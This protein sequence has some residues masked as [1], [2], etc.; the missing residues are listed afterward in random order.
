MGPKQADIL[1]QLRDF[2]ATIMKRLD[3]IDANFEKLHESIQLTKEIA[4]EAANTAD[5]ALEATKTNEKNNDM[6][7]KKIGELEERLEDQVNRSMRK[8][9]VFKGI[10]GDEKNWD[11]TA[12]KLSSII[13]QMDKTLTKDEINGWIERSHRISPVADRNRNTTNERQ[14]KT[15]NIVAQFSSWKQS[16]QIKRIVIQHNSHQNDKRIFVEQLQ[17][18]QLMERTNNAKK[19][20]KTVRDEHPDWKLYVSHPAKL[21]CK[22][23]GDNHYK[24]MKLF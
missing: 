1:E 17:T 18:P 13:S 11:E 24:L 21:M 8:T 12:N 14:K 10:E 6:L 9:L 19:H 15:K 22:K 7:M 20:R 4:I 23:P 16:E 3:Q 5:V 2:K